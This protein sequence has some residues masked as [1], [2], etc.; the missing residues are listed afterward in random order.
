MTIPQP[1]HVLVLV[2]EKT[3]R[4]VAAVLDI[5]ESAAVDGCSRGSRSGAGEAVHKLTV[6]AGVGAAFTHAEIKLSCP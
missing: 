6:N 4:V 3:V 1:P 2:R 5:V